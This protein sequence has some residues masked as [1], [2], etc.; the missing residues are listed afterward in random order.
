[1]PPDGVTVE[2]DPNQIAGF[3]HRILGCNYGSSNPAVDFPRLLDLYQ[4]GRLDLDSMITTRIAL[5]QVNDAF[6]QMRDGDGVRSV[7][8]Y[9]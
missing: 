8:L 2:I 6:A 3:E 7:V 9:G 1:M 4:A 5:E